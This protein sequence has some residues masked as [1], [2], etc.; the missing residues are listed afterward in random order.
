MGVQLSR[1]VIPARSKLS[2]RLE[3]WASSWAGSSS[4]PAANSARGWSHGRRA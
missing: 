2:P 1:I 3:S 4:R